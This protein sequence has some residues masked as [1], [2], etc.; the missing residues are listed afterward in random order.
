MDVKNGIVSL[1][2]AREVF[3]VVLEEPDFTVN[4]AETNK[5]REG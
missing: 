4:V 1:E 2:K 5:L 3:K